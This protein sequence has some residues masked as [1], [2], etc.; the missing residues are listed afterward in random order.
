MKARVMLF[1]VVLIF[2]SALDY[3][4]QELDGNRLTVY[5]KVRVFAKADRA[6]IT[7]DI[8]GVGRSLQA[9]FNDANRQISAIAEKLYAIGLSEDNISTSFFQSRENFGD[10]AFLSSKRDYCAI[11]TAYITTDSLELLEPIVVILSESEVRRIADITF[12]LINYSELRK[13]AMARAVDK[14]EEKAELISGQLGI[15]RGNIIEIEELKS[16]E[17]QQ[18]SPYHLRTLRPSGP[19][20]APLILLSGSQSESPDNSGIFAQE[21]RFDS[22]VRLVYEILDDTQSIEMGQRD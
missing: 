11:M 15:P 20:N 21:I 18:M 12:E 13:D 5:G 17:P 16:S 14:A 9:A 8:K 4:A 7:F 10:K 1:A 3:Q 19:F 22:E 6:T 2:I